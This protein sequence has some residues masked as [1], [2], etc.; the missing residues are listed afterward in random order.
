MT[1]VSTCLCACLLFLPHLFHTEKLVNDLEASLLIDSSWHGGKRVGRGAGEWPGGGSLIR[2]HG[3]VKGGAG[4]NSW[5]IGKEAPGGLGKD[6]WMNGL[7]FFSWWGMGEGG[8]QKDGGSDFLHSMTGR[9]VF[10]LN[11][12][13]WGR[14][15][16]GNL[17]LCVCGGCSLRY[18]N[19]ASNHLHAHTSSTTSFF[20]LWTC[21]QGSHWLVSW[22][23]MD[24]TQNLSWKVIMA[25][26]CDSQVNGHWLA[27]RLILRVK[28]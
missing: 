8:A 17:S 13:G 4:G 23:G 11:K 14:R 21:A 5:D 15:R 12:T 10:F 22:N 9:F 3:A 6:N 27:T 1:Q 26:C 20:F 2:L 18:W 28:S 25:M 19:K 7:I 24:T 16:P